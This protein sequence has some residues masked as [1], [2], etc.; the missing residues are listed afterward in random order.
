MAVDTPATVAIIGAGPIGLEAALYARFLGYNVHVLDK[1]RVA[2]NVLRWGHVR[3]FTPFRM[4]C[5]SLGRAALIAQDPNYRPPPNDSFLTGQQWAECYLIPLSQTDL[6]AESIRQ[7]CTVIAVSRHRL[8]KSHA[9]HDDEQRSEDPFRLLYVDQH[10]IERTLTADV[11]I[12][13]S[14]VFQTPNWMG[15]GGAPAIGEAALRQRIEYGLPDVLGSERSDYQGRRVLIVGSGH[16]A[17]T[18]L[19]QVIELMEAE[20]STSLIWVARQRPGQVSP[21]RRW[22]DDPLPQRDRLAE[23]ANRVAAGHPQVD[24]RPGWIVERIGEQDGRFLVEL[25]N[26]PEDVHRHAAATAGSKRESVLVDR[27][28]ANVGYR[29]EWGMCAELHLQLSYV[30]D[31]PSSLACQLLEQPEQPELPAAGQPCGTSNPLMTTEPNFYVLGAKSYG[32]K[33]EFLYC[34]G[35]EQIR[36]L[37]A[38]IGDRQDLDLYKSAERLPH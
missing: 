11:V 19:L 22:Q 28:V 18:T 23:A 9:W 13:A 1:G 30:T 3:M 17:A 35:L 8:W 14:G 34:M 31:G 27:I 10:G 5:S 15:P 33:S 21:V 38:I 12:D 32:R 4:N 26:G 25:A 24:F 37:F 6:L 36:R 7:R 2:E 16:S 20:P 29:P